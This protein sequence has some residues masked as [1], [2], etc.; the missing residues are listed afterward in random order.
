MFPLHADCRLTEPAERQDLHAVQPLLVTCGADGYIRMWHIPRAVFESTPYWP[1]TPL[2]TPPEKPRSAPRQPPVLG[3]PFFS[4]LAIH[5]GQWPDQVLFASPTTCAVISK[6]GVSHE[7]AQ[8]SPRKSVKV[9]VPTILDVLPDMLAGPAAALQPRP[10]SGVGAA[11]GPSEILDLSSI[12]TCLPT[13]AR[14]D[15]AFRIAYEAVVEDQNCVGDKIGW[16]RPPRLR[17]RDA[18]ALVE[19]AFFAI[20]TGS[21]LPLSNSASSSSDRPS[22]FFFRPFALPPSPSRVRSHTK[23]SGES[24]TAMRRTASLGTS[25]SGSNLV[26]SHIHTPETLAEALFPPDRD[27]DAHDFTPRLLPSFV[28]DE[29]PGAGSRD[30]ELVHARC[31]AVDPDGAKHVVA[32]GDGGLLAVW[33][34]R[35]RVWK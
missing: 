16:Y 8:H 27:R 11:S 29:L 3:P 5:P 15:G 34:R 14:S 7:R 2:F 1:S 22:L 18:A 32:V 33:T 17:R 26:P 13:D 23:T 19:D 9:W 21:I 24:S 4:T 30:Q 28:T 31:V 25:Q 6:A 12:Q 10:D 35:Q 20:P